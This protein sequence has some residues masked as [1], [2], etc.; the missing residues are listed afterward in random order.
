MSV[1]GL[2]WGEPM[3]DLCIPVRYIVG[4]VETI[5]YDPTVVISVPEVDRSHICSIGQ[6]FLPKKF[7]ILRGFINLPS[8]VRHHTRAGRAEK[9]KVGRYPLCCETM[10]VQSFPR[11][12]M[13]THRKLGRIILR[14]RLTD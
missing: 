9:K 1:A 8:T 7:E 2:E 14:L 6:D 12:E 13:P 10:T 5:C 4:F 3:H 11:A